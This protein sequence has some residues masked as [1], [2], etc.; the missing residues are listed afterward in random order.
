[1]GRS[2]ST[3]SSPRGKPVMTSADTICFSHGKESG[4]WGT[5]I[6]AL[7]EIAMKRGFTVVSIDYTGEPDP[8]A[9]VRKLCREYR[10]NAGL[11]IQQVP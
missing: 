6:T 9:R 4:P 2:A 1:M 10:R 7:A 8:D 3:T 11:N 5:K